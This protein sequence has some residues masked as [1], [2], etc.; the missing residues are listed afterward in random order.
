MKNIL[1]DIIEDD[2]LIYMSKCR[3]VIIYKNYNNTF[4]FN[5]Y[6]N[7]ESIITDDI[8][9]AVAILNKMESFVDDN[10]IWNIDISN[11]KDNTIIKY[12]HVLYWIIGG[13]EAMALYKYDWIYMSDFFIRKYKR[14]IDSV[15]K[16]SNKL[17]DVRKLLSKK[18]HMQ[19]LYDFCIKKEFF[20]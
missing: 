6:L 16:N 7:N 9:E 12:Q 8:L 13:S 14:T 2:T 5:F 11:S 20:K 15:F 19:S 17:S 10:M 3:K 18:I 1:C 4:Y